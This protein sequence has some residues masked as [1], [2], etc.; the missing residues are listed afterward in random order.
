MFAR[1][2]VGIRDKADISQEIVSRVVEVDDEI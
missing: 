1:S 2:R